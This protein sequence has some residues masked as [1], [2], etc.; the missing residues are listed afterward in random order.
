MTNFNMDGAMCEILLTQIY[1]FQEILRAGYG[2]LKPY[3]EEGKFTED[4]Y[5]QPFEKMIFSSI[6]LPSAIFDEISATYGDRL[7]VIDHHPDTEALVG[8]NIN[9]ARITWNPKQSSCKSVYEAIANVGKVDITRFKSLMTIVNA[10][11]TWNVDAKEWGVAYAMN[12]LFWHYNYFNFVDRYK[13]GVTATRPLFTDDEK[14]I[15][16]GIFKDKQEKIQKAMKEEIDHP[17]GTKS[18]L[19]M[20]AE[21]DVVSDFALQ[22]EFAHY[23]V[24]FIIHSNYQGKQTISVR[25]NQKY[26][27]QMSVA[28]A[29][30]K[31]SAGRKDIR[32]GGFGAVG[33]IICYQ[34]KDLN[35]MIDII[36]A[37]HKYLTVPMTSPP[38]GG[39]GDDVPF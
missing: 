16:E 27:A 37:T 17:D 24:F 13:E 19:F 35:A 23:K 9:G 30:R 34:E 21:S 12:A 39:F 4:K 10:F 11:E 32:G 2:K 18:V 26:D 31:V 14:G 8:N 29:V 33:N 6:Q 28:D 25:V 5:G 1:E 36:E 3:F 38:P 20:N 22:K 7:S 15:I